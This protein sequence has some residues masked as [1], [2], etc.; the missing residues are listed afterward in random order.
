MPLRRLDPREVSHHPTAVSNQLHLY[1]LFY[2]QQGTLASIKHQK[3]PAASDSQVILF[4]REASTAV[5]EFLARQFEVIAYIMVTVIN[6]GDIRVLFDSFNQ[7][8]ANIDQRLANMGQ[9]ITNLQRQQQPP[10]STPTPNTIISTTK[11]TKDG[12]SWAAD[13][14]YFYPNPFLLLISAIGFSCCSGGRLCL[15]V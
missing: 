3:S 14:G 5:I 2:S 4:K 1:L 12:T 8:S 15:P 13:I 11:G 9:Q 6:N 10:S 7:L